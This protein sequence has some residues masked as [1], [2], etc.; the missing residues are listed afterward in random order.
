MQQKTL[1]DQAAADISI[2]RLRSRASVQM[3]PLIVGSIVTDPD[4]PDWGYSLSPLIEEIRRERRVELMGEEFRF[5]DLMRWAA[6]KLITGQNYRG[7]YYGS[8]MQQMNGQGTILR[9]DENYFQPLRN[10]LPDGYQFDP[11][12]DYLLPFPIDEIT[13]NPKL[14]QNPGW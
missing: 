3:P 13:I 7:G 11:E 5:D 12:R 10:F 4:W 1:M 9:D 6:A 8:I 14:T 2:N